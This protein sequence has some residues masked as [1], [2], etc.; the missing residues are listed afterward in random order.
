[1]T[2]HNRLNRAEIQ[3]FAETF[4]DELSN[5]QEAVRLAV[6]AEEERN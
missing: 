1:V 4:K 6:A 5:A 3:S 2:L